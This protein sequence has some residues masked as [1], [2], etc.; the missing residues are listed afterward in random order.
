MTSP[1]PMHMM[2][3]AGIVK[4]MGPGE[5]TYRDVGECDQFTVNPTVTRK[6]YRSKRTSARRLVRNPVTDQAVE[7]VMIFKEFSPENLATWG[8]GEAEDPVAPAT[9]STVWL[10]R[11]VE[12]EGFLRFVGTTDLGDKVQVDAKVTLA[13][14]GELDLLT[15]DWGGF[16]ITAEVLQDDV[17]HYDFGRI[18]HGI[19]AEVPDTP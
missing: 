9:Q 4:W 19:T 17:A 15:D 8:L 13:P 16:Q 1:N 5:L 3:G 6:P 12:M 7:I 10:M 2:I 18:L 14:T 11:E